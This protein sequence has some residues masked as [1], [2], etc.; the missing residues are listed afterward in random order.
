MKKAC[1]LWHEELRK[2]GIPFIFRNDVHDEWQTETL[3]QYAEAVGKIQEQSIVDAGI[4]FNLNCALAGKS[5]I[6]AN[7]AITH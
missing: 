2:Q 3:P 7:W 5:V 4:H 1:L 6:G